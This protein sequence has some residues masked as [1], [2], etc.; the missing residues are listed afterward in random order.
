[1]TLN[2]NRNIDFY[3]FFLKFKRNFKN[4]S[5]LI[6]NFII[7]FTAVIWAF[8]ISNTSPYNLDANL[9]EAII[10]TLCSALIPNFAP[11]CGT[12]AYT[13]MI[14]YKYLPNYGKFNINKYKY[15]YKLLI[16]L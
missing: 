15:K 5:C 8:A 4:G 16:Y 13:G 10:T 1:M 9:T 7:C 6:Y 3:A 14:S 2:R 12:G 11:A